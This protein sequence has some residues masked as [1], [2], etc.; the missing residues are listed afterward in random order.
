MTTPEQAPRQALDYALLLGLSVVWGST[1]ILYK[2]ALQVL[3]W[4]Q[5]GLLRVLISALC[6]LPLV[7]HHWGRVPRKAVPALLA[8]GLLGSGIPPFLFAL[9]QTR[10]DSGV[11]GILNALT[12]IFTFMVGLAFF[13]LRVGRGKIVGLVVGLLGAVG[14]VLTEGNGFGGKAVYGL[15][16]LLATTCYGTATNLIKA[17]LQDVPP[18]TITVFSLTALAIPALIAL[19]FSGLP[20]A[21]A[22]T[23]GAWGATGYVAIMAVAG[24]VVASYAYFMLIQRTDVVFASVITYLIPVVALAWG[25]ADG[26]RLQTGHAASLVLILVAVR[27]IGKRDRSVQ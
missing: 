13:H 23:P 19:P 24:T 8:V 25:Y 20:Q 11:T 9:A 4:G 6:L 14:I 21:W 16:V 12:P 3:A 22:E 7:Y 2:E 10:L 17:Y 26:E 18:L 5:V 1:F 15:F 27:L